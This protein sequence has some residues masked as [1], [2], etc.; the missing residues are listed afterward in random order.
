M[1]TVIVGGALANKPLNGGE[2][3]V[4]LTWALG[5]KRLGFEVCFAE[6]IA[7]ENCVDERGRLAD[8]DR[9]VNRSFFERVIREFGLEGSACLVCDG[10]RRTA[11]I[12]YEDLLARADGAELLVNI[13]GHITHEEILRRPKKRVYVDLDPGFTQ[14]WH[15]DPD[16]RF[17][18][19]GHQHYVTVGVNIGTN[20][21]PIP[22]GGFTWRPILPP[23]LLDEWPARPQPDS[24]RLFTTVATWRSPYGPVE[25][26]GRRYGLKHHEF[27]KFIGLP[28]RTADAE[29][30]I[31]LNIH[32]TD[33]EDLARLQENGWRLREPSTTAPDPAAF[34]RYVQ[35]SGAEFSV[36][37][38]IYVETNCG[39]F[40]DRTGSYLASGRPALVQETGFSR[41]LPA[42]DGLL[43][44]RTLDEAVA[45]V[46]RIASDYEGHCR[47]AR[48]I[49]EEH[50]DSDRVLG[51]LLDDVGVFG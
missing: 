9:S 43:A 30:E 14:L 8:F 50:L 6:L 39:W 10:D 44:F 23:V 13:S 37:Q 26:D 35:G 31:V 1:A 19:S 33:A 16:A 15:A 48:A 7:G 11:G 25:Y 32:P 4:R 17:R 24:Q 40:S 41:N 27:R 42:G 2:A 12:S 21:C 51:E 46:E 36:A 5:L 34:R 20:G 22:T 49:A 47:A 45:G 38:G 29:F 18:L 3:W 28:G